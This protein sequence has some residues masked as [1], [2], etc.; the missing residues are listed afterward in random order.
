MTIEVLEIE[1]IETENIQRIVPLFHERNPALSSD[2]LALRVAEMASQGFQC[3]GAYLS[4]ELIGIAGFWIRTRYHTGRV[5]EADGVFVR[6]PYRSRGI[7]EKMAQRVID[8]GR[9]VGCLEGELHCY[10]SN[11]DAH[12]FWINQGYRIIAF[13]FG[14]N[15]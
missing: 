13:H 9:K 10:V 6:P 8:F 11:T 5:I 7:G 12:R 2:L 1:L 3:F 15:I 4:T 14:R